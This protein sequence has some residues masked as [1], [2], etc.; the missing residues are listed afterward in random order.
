[1]VTDGEKLEYALY[2]IIEA[3]QELDEHKEKAWASAHHTLD[4]ALVV[5]DL[6]M[7]YGHKTVT[8]ERAKDIEKRIYEG[9]GA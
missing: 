1:V 3:R 4:K 7:F 6:Q 8:K 9:R 2:R 5:I